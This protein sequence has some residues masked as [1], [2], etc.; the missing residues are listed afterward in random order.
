MVPL[1][2]MKRFGEEMRPVKLT[3][4]VLG[5]AAAKN[6][7]LFEKAGVLLAENKRNL[8]TYT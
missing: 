3:T 4:K 7:F 1:Q 2:G 5:Y 6:D 8:M